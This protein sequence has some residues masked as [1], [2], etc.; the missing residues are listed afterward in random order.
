MSQ[1]GIELYQPV[2]LWRPSVDAVPIVPT[3]WTLTV[4][5]ALVDV[6]CGFSETTVRE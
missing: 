1:P 5:E 4:R 2:V 6:L 3:V